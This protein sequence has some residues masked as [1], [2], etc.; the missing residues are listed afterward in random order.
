MEKFV[1]FLQDKLS[2]VAMAL[3]SNRYLS[4]IRDGFMGIMSLLIIGSM[5]LLL[6]FLPIPGYSD[7]MAN[8]FGANWNVF[9]MT[10]YNMTMN[11]MA[12]F[13]VIGV[14]KS[15][16][17]EYNIDETGSMFWSFAAFLMLTPIGAFDPGNFLPM[18]NFG[19]EGLFLGIITSI[20]TVEIIKFVLGRG[21]KIK[22]PETVPAN[23]SK[24]FESL[25][26][27]IF[28]AI[29]FST[30]SI[31]FALT[32]YSTAHNF[33]FTVLQTPLLSLGGTLPAMIIV[34]IIETLLFSFGLH[35]PNIVGSVMTPI[36]LALTEQNA[37][38]FAAGGELPNI[39]TTQFYGNFV[40]VGGCGA[41]IG[42]V[43]ASIFFAK[44]SQFKTLGKLSIGPAIF[45]INEPVI[46]GMPI[47][48]NPILM[49]PFII[50]P[51]VLATLTY[52]VMAIGLVPF[53]SGVNIPWT[54]PPIVS[55]LLVSGWRGALW[56]IVEIVISIVIFLPFFR[57]EDKRA[58]DLENKDGQ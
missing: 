43:I 35:G 7:F 30:I 49:I 11:V 50:T 54:T 51:I 40:K 47:V 42:L 26:P 9:F 28:V 36:W 38:A 44:S 29:I 5:F 41:T 17:K 24:S 37:A 1:N 19:A 13:V 3:A 48:L 46:F 55:G 2:P 31:L 12:L 57:L 20:L 25:I 53:T 27:G 8:T 45:N 22:L 15:L 23:V 39:I 21:W 18:K 52:L 34:L 33:V 10:P 4:A 14:A 6:A 56:Q 32:P 16:S 58:Y